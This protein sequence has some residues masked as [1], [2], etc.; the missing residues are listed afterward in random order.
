MLRSHNPP[1]LV[2]WVR[3]LEEN[4]RIDKAAG[5]IQPVADALVANP[6]V[7]D[8]LHGVP[9]GHAAHPFLTDIPIGTWTSANLLDLLGG[10]RARPAARRLIGIGL[11]AAVPT[12]LTGYA[13]WASIDQDEARRVG[14]VHATSNALA[15]GFYAASWVARGRDE[16]RGTALALTGSLC[17]TVG[18]YLGGHLATGRKIGTRD[19]AFK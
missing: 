12:V 1:R 16:R 4:D 3:R 6:G 15:I 7:R 9:L 14:V 2:S 18:G 11:V 13:E 17:A 10:R 5:K 8:V 19:P